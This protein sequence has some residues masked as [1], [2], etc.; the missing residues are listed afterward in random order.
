MRSGA[1]GNFGGTS[2]GSPR[3]TSR[4]A[5]I[6]FLCICIFFLVHVWAYNFVCDDTFITLRY[7]RN[8][9]TGNGLVFN[10]H[11]RVEG[12]SSPLWT[13]VLAG[14]GALGIELLTAARVLG[15]IAALLTLF[16][17]Y[18]LGTAVSP[19][20]F[21]ALLAPTFLAANGSF[22]CWTASGMETTLYLCL[23]VASFYFVLTDQLR[24]G[25]LATVALL[26]LRPEA[27]LFFLLL[28]SAQYALYPGNRTRRLRVWLVAGGASL[29]AL[30]VARF[31]YYGSWLPNT[32][33]AKV[34]GG[35]HAFNRGLHYLLD[36][37]EDHEGLLLFC[38]PVVY[39][40]ILRD[41]RF[42]LLALGTLLLWLTTILEGGD[43]QPMYRMALSP[44]PLLFVLDARVFADACRVLAPHVPRLSLRKLLIGTAISLWVTVQATVPIVGTYYVR[45]HYHKEVE[46]PEWTLVG[47]WLKANARPGDSV[48][49]V[50]IGAVS[51]YSGLKTIDMMGLTDK[52]IARVQVPQMGEGWAGHEKHDGQYVLGR[53]PTY[54]L[55]GNIDVT[56]KPRDP[57]QVP[58]IPYYSSVI[59]AR[60]GD[61][62][63]TDLLTREY[64]PQSALIAP[65]KYLNFYELRDEFRRT[66]RVGVPGTP[67]TQRQAP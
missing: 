58:F 1:G 67:H 23:L 53:H 8:L 17:T 31:L 24:A 29:V 40:L 35:L 9:A 21:V 59:W 6:L 30:Y 65:G 66:G 56:E 42:R 48:A 37:A 57:S 39:G 64:V 54:I 11:E 60:E 12:F 14:L 13:L 22:A 2:E 46:V 25:I 36:Y 26:F 45:Y 55:A 28:T 52:H 15:V 51:Y 41:L 7:A 50:P 20:P 19:S 44:L 38:V 34:G 43:G 49:A 33:F 32:Y 47:K 27:V 16:L 18:R 61:L 63:G 5:T 4:L 62:Y 3:P 10:P